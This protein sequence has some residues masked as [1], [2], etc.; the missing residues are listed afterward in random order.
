MELRPGLITVKTVSLCKGTGAWS[1]GQHRDDD[2]EGDTE[3]SE[4]YRVRD[5]SV[6]FLK[7]PS[8]S[9]ECPRV[10]VSLNGEGLFPSS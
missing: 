3:A 5:E 9:R 8:A 10:L 1:P 4:T 6:S 2:R 7:W